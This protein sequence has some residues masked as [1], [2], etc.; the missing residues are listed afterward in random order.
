MTTSASRISPGGAVRRAR[1]AVRRNA[2]PV[3]HRIRET[4]R[5]IADFGRIEG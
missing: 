3:L 5:R 2:A 4:G 1:A